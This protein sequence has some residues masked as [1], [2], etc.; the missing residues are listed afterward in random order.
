MASVV[1]ESR[2]PTA[3]WWPICQAVLGQLVDAEVAHAGGLAGAHLEDGHDE[4]GV[5]VGRREPLDDGD[6]AVGAGVDDEPGE[7]RR[8]VAGDLVGDD[9]RRRQPSS[10]RARGRRPGP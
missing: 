7:H 1:V 3:C 8:P 10:R 2:S 6:L 4:H 9:D 5:A